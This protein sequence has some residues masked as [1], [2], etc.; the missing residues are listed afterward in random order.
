MET[1]EKTFYSRIL[2]E[3]AKGLEAFNEE[4]FIP[5]AGSI[6]V[7]LPP[8][9]TEIG[10]V[11]LPD[12]SAQERCFARVAAVPEDVHCPVNP[13]DWVLFRPGSPMPLSLHGRKD[14]ALLQ[15]TDGP[16]SE[17]LGLIRN[18]SLTNTEKSL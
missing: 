7:V 2:E 10:G 18:G 8:L 3:E 16:D 11:K 6:L 14:L 12:A 17:V 13:G 5:A 9:I 15:Y 1:M 4:D